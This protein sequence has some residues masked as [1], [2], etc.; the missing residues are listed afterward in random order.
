MARDNRK[1]ILYP[2]NRCAICGKTS[3]ETTIYKHE[4][5]FGNG[6]RAKS[7]QYGCV[8]G[9]CLEDHDRGIKDSVHNKPLGPKD[10][11]LKKDYET[12]FIALYGFDTFMAVFHKNYLDDDELYYARLREKQVEDYYHVSKSRIGE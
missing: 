7:I 1:S 3:A 6:N 4:V 9:L 8:C 5:F 10:M 11:K 12:E 2:L